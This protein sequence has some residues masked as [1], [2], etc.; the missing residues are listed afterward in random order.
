M[1]GF[2]VKID[3][4]SKEEKTELVTLLNNYGIKDYEKDWDVKMLNLSTHPYLTFDFVQKFRVAKN[5]LAR[6]KLIKYDELREIIH[7]D[8]LQV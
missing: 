3:K 2:S 4:L 8:L 5:S 1:K 6:Y 7:S